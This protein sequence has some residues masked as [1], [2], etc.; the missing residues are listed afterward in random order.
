MRDYMRELSLNFACFDFIVPMQGDPVFLE[1]NANGQFAWVENLT[2]L[3]IAKAIANELMSSPPQKKA[4]QPP[5]T[6][7]DLQ[8]LSASLSNENF[9]RLCRNRNHARH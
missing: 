8:L 7:T 6:A 3:P 5:L 9:R 2:G 4:T 1:A